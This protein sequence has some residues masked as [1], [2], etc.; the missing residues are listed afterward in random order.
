MRRVIG[1]REAN[2]LESI[3]PCKQWHGEVTARHFAQHG[4]KRALEH[5]A[6]SGFRPLIEELS[7]RHA[8]PLCRPT[9]IPLEAGGTGTL[10]IPTKPAGDS[11]LKPAAIPT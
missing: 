11:D 9:C 4:A 2:S 10:L 7:L 3:D 8:R 5:C 1:P 6:S